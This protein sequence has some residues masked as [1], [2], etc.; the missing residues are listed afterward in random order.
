MD[1]D[2]S[3]TSIS[4]CCRFSG[5]FSWIGW[6]SSGILLLE[7]IGLAELGVVCMCS[8]NYVSLVMMVSVC[9]CVCVHS[10]SHSC[11]EHLITMTFA[12]ISRI[13]I[14]YCINRSST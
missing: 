3:R 1:W 12:C 5:P 14:Q 13:F 9:V 7:P 6:L 2:H 4:V 10:H 8:D 11:S